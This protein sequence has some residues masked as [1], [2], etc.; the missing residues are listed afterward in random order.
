MAKVIKGMKKEREELRNAAQTLPSL[1]E[2][3][4]VFTVVEIEPTL[5]EACTLPGSPRKKKTSQPAAAPA[6]GS[7]P[8]AAAQSLLRTSRPGECSKQWYPTA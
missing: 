2:E 1:Q 8:A 7:A 5:S 3:Q 6:G 4:V